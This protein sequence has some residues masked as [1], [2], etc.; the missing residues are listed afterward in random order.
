MAITNLFA[1]IPCA[2]PD[3]ITQVLL[4]REG[5]RIERIISHGQASPP[6]FWYD[7][8]EDEWVTLLSGRAGIEFDGDMNIREMTPGDFLHIPAHRRHRIAWT[9]RDAD[10]I[11]LAIFLPAQ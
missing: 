10:S 3:E 9:D 4:E 7:Q 11:W 8:D 1:D 2:L 5:L 6:G